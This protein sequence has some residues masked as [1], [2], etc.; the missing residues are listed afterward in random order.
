[1]TVS[2][3]SFVWVAL[4]VIFTILYVYFSVIRPHGL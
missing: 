2:Q 1:M 4:A 3:K